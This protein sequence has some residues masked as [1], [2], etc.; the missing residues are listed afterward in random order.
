MTSPPHQVTTKRRGGRERFAGIIVLLCVPLLTA[1]IV[2]SSTCNPGGGA[3]SFRAATEA[4]PAGNLPN[5]GSH[6]PGA[7]APPA[8]GQVRPRRRGQE[9]P[10]AFFRRIGQRFFDQLQITW[11]VI[12]NGDNLRQHRLHRQARAA[13]MPRR[14]LLLTLALLPCHLHP[15][16]SA[17][18]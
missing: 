3:A 17:A 18:V 15:G 12:L 13:A 11:S 14:P 1:T 16:T 5:R 7:V 4:E 9:I 8:A 10:A 6:Q 2:A